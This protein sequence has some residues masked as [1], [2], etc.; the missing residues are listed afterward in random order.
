MESALR[1]LKVRERRELTQEKEYRTCQVM[2]GLI[3][4]TMGNMH[5]EGWELC[6][7]IPIPSTSAYQSCFI[8]VF[9]R[10]LSKGSVVLLDKLSEA[11]S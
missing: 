9:S 4:K 2:S 6:H 10:P 11:M 7:T 3:E 8:L 5:S 1:R